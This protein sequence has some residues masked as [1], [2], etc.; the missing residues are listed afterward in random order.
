M[1]FRAEDVETGPEVGAVV[2]DEP[3]LFFSNVTEAFLVKAVQ[4]GIVI[5]LLQVPLQELELERAF[6]SPTLLLFL[7]D[8]RVHGPSC[9]FLRLLRVQNNH[10]VQLKRLPSGRSHFAEQFVVEFLVRHDTSVYLK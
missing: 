10:E 9:S 5:D 2:V 7:D 4:V 3:R 6:S 8:Q 1:D